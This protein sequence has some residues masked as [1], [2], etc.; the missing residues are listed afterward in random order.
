MGE[1]QR[2]LDFFSLDFAL[3]DGD[4]KLIE[5]GERR[6]EEVV[7]SLFQSFLDK[8]WHVAKSRLSFLREQLCVEGLDGHPGTGMLVYTMA[9]QRDGPVRN[10]ET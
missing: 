1:Q 2:L 9:T 8:G 6:R 7:R 4:P 3:V 5:E 10:S